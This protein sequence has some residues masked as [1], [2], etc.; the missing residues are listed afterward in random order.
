MFIFRF[1]HT[2]IQT[3]Q[4]HTGLP[5]LFSAMIL[6]FGPST[7]FVQASP[8]FSDGARDDGH[9]PGITHVF[10]AEPT[11]RNPPGT[12][13]VISENGE[14]YTPRVASP[15]NPVRVGDYRISIRHEDD[16][17]QQ[18]SHTYMAQAEQ[19]GA[20]DGRGR[21]VGTGPNDMTLKPGDVRLFYLVLVL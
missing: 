4:S 18:P 21:L 17:N 9:R 2:A 20:R 7:L 12:Y 1:D 15:G 8:T 6:I 16:P 10:Q 14:P 3:S 13:H 11:P 19:G 5:S